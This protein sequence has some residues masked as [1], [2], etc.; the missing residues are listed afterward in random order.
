MPTGI[1]DGRRGPKPRPPEEAKARRKAALKRARSNY[2]AK[3]RAVRRKKALA[4]GR[5]IRKNCPQAFLLSRR[6]AIGEGLS[7]RRKLSMP[8]LT[9]LDHYGCIHREDFRSAEQLIADYE[10]EYGGKHR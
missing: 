3:R 7:V 1:H 8:A 4:A 6:D 9:Y 2:D 5:A 10:R